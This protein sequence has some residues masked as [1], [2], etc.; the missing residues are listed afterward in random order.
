MKTCAALFVVAIALAGPS[1][2]AAGATVEATPGASVFEY[3]LRASGPDSPLGFLAL[4][5]RTL[6]RFIIAADKV[7][8]SAVEA[9]P[10]FCSRLPLK[11]PPCSSLCPP[12]LW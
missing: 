12:C 7:S 3:A 4:P 1:L 8:S 2:V 6:R 9:P 11:L 5:P 10:V